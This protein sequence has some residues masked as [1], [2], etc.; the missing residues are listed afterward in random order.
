MEYVVR[1]GTSPTRTVGN[2]NKEDLMKVLKKT[3]IA[4]IAAAALLVSACTGTP[5]YDAPAGTDLVIGISL[6]L[7]G[8][9]LASAGPAQ[10]GAELAVK[11][12]AIEGYTLSVVVLDHAING[13]HDPAQAAA[14][15]QTLVGN[16]KVVGVVGPFNSGSAKTQIPV[17]SEAHLL[18]CS[19]SNTNPDLTKGDAGAELRGGRPVNYIRVAAT[20]DLQGPAVADYAVANGDMNVFVI[21]DTEVY[22]S[23]IAATF[24]AQLVTAMG[25]VAGTASA[26]PTT[27]DF[28][29]IVTTALAT[30]PDAV[31]YGGVTSS[32]GGLLRKAMILGGLNVPLYAGDGLNDGNGEGSYIGI[33]GAD[34]KNS[35]SAVAAIHD[36]P[37]AT[38]FAAAYSAE[39][40]EQ[41]GS[42]SASGYACAQ[43]IIAAIEAAIASGT[44]TRE[45]VRAAAVDPTASYET[46]LGPVGFDANG[47][48]TQRVIS[49]Y[50][51]KNGD[52][53]FDKQV[54]YAAE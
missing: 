12:A 52:W 24:S 18:Q 23:G 6:P 29:A 48:T 7:N 28:S 37:D 43:V 2:S 34:A 45:S 5:A 27:T 8:S 11:E 4:A 49:L 13:A 1:T 46:V 25:T 32:G 53:V 50:K 36:I 16:P 30:N 38:A 20:D 41:P 21:D 26:A 10:M 51:V 19:P 40:N 39:Y 15:M 9:A 14:D 3:G 54:T 47:D 22:G 44:V 31:F 35:Y 17:S 42:Y 33:A